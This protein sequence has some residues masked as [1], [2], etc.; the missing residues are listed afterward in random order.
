MAKV[1]FRELK[2][3]DKFTLVETSLPEYVNIKVPLSRVEGPEGELSGPFN[4]INLT[5]GQ[6]RTFRDD[7]R[8]YQVLTN[9]N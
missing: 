6:P 2:I 7:E 5:N 8:V 9:P 1:A 3:G 4:V